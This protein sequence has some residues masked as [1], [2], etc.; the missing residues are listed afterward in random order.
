MLDELNMPEWYAAELLL[1]GKEREFVG[2]AVFESQPGQAENEIGEPVC[3]LFDTS[4]PL[5]NAER[6]SLA[7]AA[8]P[9]LIQTILELLRAFPR[10][11]TMTQRQSDAIGGAFQVI[12][13]TMTENEQWDELIAV[14][15]QIEGETQ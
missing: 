10:H 3:M 9:Q 11:P 14:K 8:T 12:R 5:V 4:G 1:P 7:L 15:A 6:N 2:L 13:S